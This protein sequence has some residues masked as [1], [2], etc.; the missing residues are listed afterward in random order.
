MRICKLIVFLT[1]GH[2]ENVELGRGFE[3]VVRSDLD[4]LGRSARLERV[5]NEDDLDVEGV[6]LLAKDAHRAHDIEQIESVVEECSELDGAGV[7]DGD[8]GKRAMGGMSR[9]SK[10]HFL[11]YGMCLGCEGVRCVDERTK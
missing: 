3:S 6:Q 1:S 8:L 9:R 2:E 10:Q 11:C 7:T 5:G 4:L